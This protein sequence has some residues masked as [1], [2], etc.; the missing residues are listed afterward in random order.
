M[1]IE[2]IKSRVEEGGSLEALI[3]IMI[4]VRESGRSVDE[5]G[6]QMLRRISEERRE[7]RGIPGPVPRDPEGAGLPDGTG[8]ERALAAL[9][10][11]VPTAPLRRTV[12]E[13]AQQL[14]DAR[15]AASGRIARLHQIMQ[16]LGQTEPQAERRNPVEPPRQA[17]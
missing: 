8:R 16:L 3:R 15:Q 14:L 9:P 7:G 1:R 10:K 17:G 11:L 6:F 13:A 2:D 4:H 5:R 12:V